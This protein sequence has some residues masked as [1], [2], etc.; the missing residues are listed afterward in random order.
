MEQMA[1][2][3]KL[4]QR[5][6]ELEQER[7]NRKEAEKE[8]LKT[9][10]RFDRFVNTIPC[11]L[12]DY[13][14][15]TNGQNRF[16]YISSQ[17]KEIFEY[18]ADRII[19]NSDLLWNT[20]HPHDLERLM[21]KDQEANQ[22][23]KLFQS[24]IR[25]IP[26]SGRMKWIQLTSMPSLQKIESQDIWSGVILDITG[27]K[28]AEE[29]KNQLILKLQRALAKVKTLSGLLPICASCKKIRDDKGYWNQ[30]ESYIKTHS[31][32]EFSHG[33]CPDCAKKL[34]PE[35]DLYKEENN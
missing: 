32:A 15:W 33:I 6:K 2:Y 27:R 28:R 3:E 21:R 12:Y 10:Q 9:K 16:L 20:V 11:V 25:I 22:A 30:I 5:V 35:F 19:E 24:E 34:Y 31:E 1:D 7:Q 8:L 14:L 18:E 17:C 29:E 26:P 13:V 4:V 23:R